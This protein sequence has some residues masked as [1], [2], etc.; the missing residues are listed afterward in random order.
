MNEI[1]NGYI[2]E[3]SEIE[4]YSLEIG[5]VDEAAS[6]H[7]ND[8]A[9]ANIVDEK[10]GLLV[11]EENVR[12]DDEGNEIDIDVENESDDDKANVNVDDVVNEEVFDPANATVD[13]M[14]NERLVVGEARE[15][16]YARRE[17]NA[18]NQTGRSFDESYW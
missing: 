11:D 12:E 16:G 15:V 9:I 13:E 6:N 4:F 10:A 18:E 17:N 5:N 1:R 2:S 8:T 14:M 3:K 7:G